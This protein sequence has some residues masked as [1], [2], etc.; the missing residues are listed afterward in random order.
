DAPAAAP[1]CR[2]GGGAAPVPVALTALVGREE[3]VAAVRALRERHRVVTLTGPGGAGKSRLA[4]ECVRGDGAAWWVELSAVPDRDGLLATVGTALGA[5]PAAGADP[6]AELRRA[7]A[8]LEG[9]LVLDTCEHLVA[10]ARELVEALVGSAPGLRVL[11]TSRRPLGVAGELTWPVPPLSLPDAGERDLGAVRRS[12]A[13]QLFCERAARARPGFTLDE[14]NAAD[15]AAVCTLLDGLPLALELAAAHAAALS[16]AKIASLLRE[17][18]RLVSGDPGGPGAARHAGLRAT[19]DWSYGLLTPEEARFLDRLSVLAGPFPLEAGIAVA[20][21]GLDGDGLHLLLSLVRQSLVASTGTDRFRLLDTLR[22]HAAERLAAHP[23][24]ERAARDRHARW[25][26]E[27]AREADRGLRGR[28]PDRDRCLAELRLAAQDVRAAL[29]H[30]LRPPRHLPVTGV[31]LVC[32]LSWFWSFEGAFPLARSWIAEADVAGPHAPPLDALLHL[33]AG[34]HAKSVGDLRTAASRSAAAAA[35]FADLGDVRGEAEALLNLG[36]A[37]WA[38]GRPHEAAAAHERSAALHASVGDD[39]G[40]G[41]ALV[42]R[43]RTALDGGDAPLAREL[44]DRAHA[45]LLRTGDQH[46]VGLAL[47][48]LARTCLC[49]GDADAT[50]D[51]AGRALELFERV[52]YVEGALA[53][54]QTLGQVHAVCGNPD[55]ARQAYRR[56]TASALELDHTAATVEG[57]ELLAALSAACGD[58]GRAAVLLGHADGLRERDGLPRTPL[59]ARR[60]ASWAPRAGAALADRWEVLRASGART[61]SEELLAD[62][63]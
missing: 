9:V 56:A 57:F 55:A 38:D 19:I 7:A 16:P 46:L 22:A 31:G 44:L 4:A 58:E 18:T 11:A 49:E 14:G 34:M 48:Q 50:E 29:E 5:V 24:E 35:A 39:A 3:Q 47:E 42:L 63:E 15:V 25:F 52:G 59:Q 21:E 51:L 62:L 8:R 10:A 37:A 30:C 17:R 53:A 40:A 61:P 12:R 1:A 20:G 41:L 45:V 28:G 60:L 23:E 43:A 33:A 36:T 27:F 6:L 13:V 26:E 2:G 32:S 54:R